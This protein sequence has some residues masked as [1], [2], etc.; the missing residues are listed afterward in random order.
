MS[1]DLSSQIA[2]VM[3]PDFGAELAKELGPN[4][5][6]AGN[7]MF[8][9]MRKSNVIFASDVWLDTTV[10]GFESVSEAVRILKAAGRYWFLNPVASVRRSMLIAEQLRKLPDLHH[11]F[12]VRN[13]LPQIGCFSL[14]DNNTLVYATKRL[15]NPPLGDFR[16]IEDK[17]NPPNRAYLKLWE[18]LALLDRYPTSSESAIDLGASPGGWTWVM[19]S[20]GAQVLAV[21]K[22][23][24]AANI[25]K[26]PHVRFLRESAFALDPKTLNEPVDWLLCDVAC[27]P[28]RTLALINKWLDAGK[29]KQLIFTIKL[30][31]QTDLNALEPFEAIPGAR[32]LHLLHNKH[33]VTFF[34]PAPPHLFAQF[35]MPVA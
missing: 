29:A 32:V 18:A 10:L 8:S 1:R 14:L 2:Y 3:H 27:Y 9:A 23:P 24:L 11:S 16:F 20:L 7:L 31:G 15:K 34:Y 26:L 4:C 22:A 28:E 5:Q 21:D 33:E 35:S 30:Q 25:A 6:T 12:P 19:Q 13:L 17:T